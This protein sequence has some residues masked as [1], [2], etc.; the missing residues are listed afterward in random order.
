MSSGKIEPGSVPHNQG[1]PSLIDT[2][3]KL[4]HSFFAGVGITSCRR[5]DLQTFWV[6]DSTNQFWGIN[7]KRES[8]AM[9]SLR[10]L[11]AGVCLM[12]SLLPQFRHRICVHTPGGTITE[13]NNTLI[14]AF[15]EQALSIPNNPALANC[16]LS[17]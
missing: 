7:E 6:G 17:L 3:A 9:G 16:F 8:H 15:G 4:A 2:I 12:V 13:F 10:R 11:M 1:S 14:K 5:S